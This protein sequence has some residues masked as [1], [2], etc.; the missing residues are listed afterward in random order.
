MLP[1]LLIG[2][3]TLPASAQLNYDPYAPPMK[4]EPP[5]AED[6]TLNW[7]TYYASAA[8]QRDYMRKWMNGWCRGNSK[9]IKAQVKANRRDINK[10][11][12]AE[13]AGR[14]LGVGG[15][16]LRVLDAG[17]QTYTLVTHPAGVSRVSVTGD[18]PAQALRRGMWVRFQGQVD[19]HG[20][21]MNEL[22][23]LDVISV[24]PNFE[25]EP[26]EANRLATIT[27]RVTDMRGN[28]LQVHVDAGS[29]RRLTFMV[30]EEAILHVNFHGVALAGRGDRVTA[31]G[32]RYEQPGKPP[33]HILFASD[34]TVEKPALPAAAD[35]LQAGG[36]ASAFKTR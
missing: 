27:G 13:I 18:L 20:E 7:P 34:I 25:F 36:E 9:R 35:A 4:D 28:R 6:G 8:Y 24:A 1:L 23:A 26:V 29:L 14:V 32:R 10:M 19:E 3:W 31:K 11:P 12:K 33:V 15:G 5:V 16:M 21:G 17:G 2:L 22:T 30:G